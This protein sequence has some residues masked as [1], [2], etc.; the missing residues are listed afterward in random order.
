[1]E[2]FMIS[3]QINE[4]IKNNVINFEMVNESKN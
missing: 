3:K 4:F 1:M 2:L